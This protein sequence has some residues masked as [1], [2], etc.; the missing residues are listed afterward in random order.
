MTIKEFQHE[1]LTWDELAKKGELEAV[2]DPDG[3]SRK[4]HYIHSIHIETLKCAL[5]RMR[6][7]RILD[8]G[9]GTGRISRWLVSRGWEVL[10]VDISVGMLAKAKEL[11]PKSSKVSFHHFDGLHLP[12]PDS[13]FEASATVYVLQ[14]AIRNT[15][16]LTKI[17]GELHRVLK[18]GGKLF[19]IEI[20]DNQLYSYEKYKEILTSIGFTLI[21]HEPVRLRSDRFMG[22]A[23]KPFIP[24]KLIPLLGRFGIWECRWRNYQNKMNPDWHDHFYAFEKNQYNF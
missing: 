22:L 2:L 8:F 7:G 3:S 14:Y 10:G 4:N 5:K 23:E 18:P 11:T 21:H 9:C 6:K 1:G 15:D 13:M 24:M 12:S 16:L 17:A 20:T 19:C